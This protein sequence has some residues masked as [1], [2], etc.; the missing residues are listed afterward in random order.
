MFYQDSKS[1]TISETSTIKDEGGTDDRDGE[2]DED[3]RDNDDH[4]DDED[5]EEDVVHVECLVKAEETTGGILEAAVQDHQMTSMQDNH[6]ITILKLRV[7]GK[8]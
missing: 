5:D 8:Q 6:Q 2:D 1:E 3:D 4:E 7:L